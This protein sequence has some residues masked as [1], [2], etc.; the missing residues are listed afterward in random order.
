MATFLFK[1]EPSDF[2]FDDLVREKRCVWTGVSNPAAL[3]QLRTV[4]KGDD[5]LIYH[6]GDERAIVGLARAASGAYEDPK[7]PGKNDRGEPKFAVVDLVPV[8]AAKTPIDLSAI[9]A[10]KRFAKFPLVTQGRLS[11]MRVESGLDQALQS[12]AGL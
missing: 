12:L 6:T 10:D 3:N 1:T 7:K 2:S 8:R 5:V 9:K 4:R 11:V